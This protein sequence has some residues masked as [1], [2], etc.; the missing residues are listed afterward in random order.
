MEKIFETMNQIDDTLS[1]HDN[2]MTAKE[3]LD[4]ATIIVVDDARTFDI[5]DVVDEFAKDRWDEEPLD[6][7]IEPRSD[8][9][10]VSKEEVQDVLDKIATCNSF[11]IKKTWKNNMLSKKN[12]LTHDDK[13][14]ILKQ[15]K[16]GDYNYT[17][18]SNKED[19]F[20]THL[21]VFITSRAFKLSKRIFDGVTM[22]IKLKHT[23]EEGVICVLSLH[24]SRKHDNHPYAEEEN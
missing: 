18:L 1:L 22:Y 21:H 14:L 11:D 17:L 19:D 7:D 23:P 5:Q 16:L 20:G 3:A 9:I 6:E 15:L 13:V 10:I 24:D 12:N 8:K 2:I 4:G